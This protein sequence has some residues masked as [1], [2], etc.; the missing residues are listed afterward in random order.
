MQSS[1]CP[2][3]ALA[4]RWCR[5]LSRR[6]DEVALWEWGNGGTRPQ[7]WSFVR[8]DEEAEQRARAL[9]G[10]AGD[11]RAPVVVAAT[12][13]VAEFVIG[14]LAAWKAGRAAA[15]E[16]AGTGV[17]LPA[18]PWPE[19]MPV[20]LVKRTSGSTGAPR[21]LLFNADQVVADVDQ[22]LPTMALDP[23]WI[24]L[25]AVSPAHSYGFSNLV[26]PLLFHGMRLL[27]PGSVLPQAIRRSQHWLEAEAGSTASLVIPA[28]PAMWRAWLDSAAVAPDGVARAISAGAMLP[29]ALEQAALGAWGLK[30]HN[31]YGSSE[32]GGIAYDD[33]DQVRP[34]PGR[35]GRP[36]AG[37][38]LSIDDTGRVV[39]H[40]RACAL[41]VWSD[42]GFDEQ[43]VVGQGRFVSTDLGRLGG[44]GVLCL[45]GR[46]DDVVNLAGRK[47]NPESVEAI[48]RAHDLVE[49]CVVF[50]IESGDAAR[51]EELVACVRL[52]GVATADGVRRWLAGRLPAWQQ[53]RHWWVCDDLR[54]DVRGKI[55]RAVWRRRFGAR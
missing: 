46:A 28:V 10:G 23:E 11:R 41:G 7:S 17:P 44:D 55:P 53:P 32:C 4:D 39:V 35:V 36:V 14:V 43:S 27:A 51:G 34:E 6:G 25:A 37:V 2:A 5:V 21:H 40:S 45:G 54:P 16:E 33:S 20:A 1:P 24:N 49:H 52:R 48:L 26:T 12:G 15:L 18:L 22:L 38:C 30:I 29:T 47:V 31:F 3:A 42:D 19:T 50:G 8:L 13:S 9:R